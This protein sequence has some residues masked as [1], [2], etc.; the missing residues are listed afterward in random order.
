[1]S[2]FTQ[3][4][5]ESALV[6]ILS[7]CLSGCCHLISALNSLRMGKAFLTNAPEENVPLVLVP[8]SEAADEPKSKKPN[9]VEEQKES[10]RQISTQVVC[11]A[12]V[13]VSPYFI[14]SLGT[15]CL[16]ASGIFLRFHGNN[17]L[18]N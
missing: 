10:R 1:M 12:T 13:E 14:M 6:E 11:V 9:A 18:Q 2:F 15:K 7:V 8:K 4:F 3:V 5:P 17:I 16:G